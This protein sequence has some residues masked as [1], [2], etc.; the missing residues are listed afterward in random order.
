[1][2]QLLE[3]G[4]LRHALRVFIFRLT[5]GMLTSA[6]KSYRLFEASLRFH[7]YQQASLIAETA[8]R[9]WPDAID[10]VSMQCTLAFKAGALP[11]AFALLERCLFA[12]DFRAVDRVLFCTGSR[13]RDLRQSDEVF[14]SLS[15]R[16]YL[17]LAQRPMR[18]SQRPM[19]SAFTLW[20]RTLPSCWWATTTP[21]TSVI[22]PVVR[23][24][25]TLPRRR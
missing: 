5:R 13:P 3:L 8:R 7:Q 24:S 20:P 21:V 2:T 22:S 10:V 9:R 15:Q 11:E 6:S 12:A 18:W 4:R 17:D 19:W 16:T 23:S 25:R 14:R 1:M